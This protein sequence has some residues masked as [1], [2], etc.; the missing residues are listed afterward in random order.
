MLALARLGLKIGPP[1]IGFRCSGVHV[2]YFF[3]EYTVPHMGSLIGEHST[4]ECGV[5]DG[6]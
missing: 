2:C 6:I 3:T 4:L 5:V 1:L